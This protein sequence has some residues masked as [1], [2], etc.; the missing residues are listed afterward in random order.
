MVV[1][2][3]LIP[4]ALKV[5]TKF[6]VYYTF[7]QLD[8]SMQNFKVN[9][10]SI[11][12]FIQLKQFSAWVESDNSCKLHVGVLLRLNMQSNTVLLLC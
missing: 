5:A 7:F 2:L 4:P 8:L 10:V 11:I 6:I 12:L 3:R 9:L 1:L